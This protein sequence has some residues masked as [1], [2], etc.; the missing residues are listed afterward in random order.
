MRRWSTRTKGSAASCYALRGYALLRLR[1][2]DRSEQDCTKALQL[3][4]S[5]VETLAWR[6]AAR[7]ETWQWRL[8]FK[9]LARARQLA[10]EPTAYAELMARYYE[11]ALEWFR[12]QIQQGSPRLALLFND[13]GWINL[14]MRH[15]ARA[16]RDFELS[17]Q[18]D[19]HLEQAILGMAEATLG[20]GQAVQAIEFCELALR[21]NRKIAGKALI[22]QVRAVHAAGQMRSAV[23]ALQRLQQL[24]RRSPSLLHRWRGCGWRSRTT[25][26]RSMTG[27]G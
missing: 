6:A 7:A 18:Q 24:A 5:D 8:A 14:S 13:R 17:L 2:F 27:R 19:P 25:S 10:D 26:A 3:G 11:P 15:D 16:K 21:G 4:H 12:R 20:L 9:D 1:Q 22:C 23:L